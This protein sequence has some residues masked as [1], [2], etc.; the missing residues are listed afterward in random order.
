[1]ESLGGCLPTDGGTHVLTLHFGGGQLVI[2][3][4]K[5]GG[6]SH[7]GWTGIYAVQDADTF[8]AGGPALY[9]SVDFGLHGDRLVTHLV[10][11]DFP[12][13]TPWSDE[14]DGP[15]AEQRTI[16]KPLADTIC[17]AAIYDTAPFTRVG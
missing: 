16:G 4:S 5:D 15:G 14:Q 1:M 2:G 7:E 17:Q 6:P 3:N 9:I 11:D 12:D 10:R 8:A 13:H